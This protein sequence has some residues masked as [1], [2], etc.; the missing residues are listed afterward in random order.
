MAIRKVAVAVSSRSVLGSSSLENN[1][2]DSTP[3]EE[4]DVRV[5]ADVEVL[6]IRHGHACHNAM[7]YHEENSGK[8][9]HC[10]YPDPPLTD[11][12]VQNSIANGK[13]LKAQLKALGWKPQFVGSSSMVR[14]IETANAMF[15][16]HHV[17]PLPFFKET[18]NALGGLVGKAKCNMPLNLTSQKQA[19]KTLSGSKSV[20]WKFL[21][22]G[23]FKLHDPRI[24]WTI[25]GR[26]RTWSINDARETVKYSDFRAFLG[27]QIIPGLY[28][29]ATARKTGAVKLA[30]VS[31]SSTLKTK[32]KKYFK[33]KAPAGEKKF[34]FVN[35]AAKMFRYKYDVKKRQLIEREYPQSCQDVSPLASLK[36]WGKEKKYACPQDYKRCWASRG[37]TPMGQ[38]MGDAS[39]KVGD[40]SLYI[41]DRTDQSGEKC[42]TR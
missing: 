15:P 37:E 6:F 38:Y 33:C 23:P 40:K 2:D 29:K 10:E 1:T 13:L 8:W 31:H 16:S 30:I 24:K 35:N 11:C 26:R 36:K 20:E 21:N 19:V 17:H 14:T 32:L 12:G 39:G 9:H 5:V 3:A 28:N 42:C 4:E 34:Y 22:I 18:A 27:E 7:N 25:G 41:K